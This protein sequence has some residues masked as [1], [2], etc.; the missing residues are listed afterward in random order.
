MHESENDGVPTVAV[1][2]AGASGTLTAVHLARLWRGSRP[3]RVVMYEAA[4]LPGQ[5][6]AYSTDDKCHLLNVPAGRMSAIDDDPGHFLRWIQRRVPGVD[7]ESF[8]PRRAYGWYLGQL[9]A[10][11]AGSI[12]LRVHRRTVTS[13]A[14]VPDG[15]LVQHA[16]GY[17]HAHAV[18]LASG[19]APPAPLIVGEERLPDHPHHIA[20][21]WAPGAMDA[22]RAL[23]GDTGVVL[24][25]GSGLTAVDVALAVSGAGQ[26]R[27][28]V[29]VSRAG[30]LPR[31]H[32]T[33]LP[34]PWP[35][36]LPPGDG[37][38][39]LD[40]LE[41]HIG[42]ELRRAQESGHDWRSVI[43]GLRAHVS[44]L[45]ERLPEAERRRF[46]GGPV[47]N[48][49]VHRHRMAPAVAAVIGELLRRGSLTVFAGGLG[50]LDP[51]EGGWRATMRIDGAQ[52][53]LRA[54][55]VVNCTGPDPDPAAHRGGLLKD[56]IDQGLAR[57]DPLGLGVVTDAFGAVLDA[58][59][60]ADPDLLTLGALRRGQLW[61]STAIPEIRKQAAALA[62]TLTERLTHIGGQVLEARQP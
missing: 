16:D 13:L 25:V 47:R 42:D 24:L 5:G 55:V 32:V 19:N 53:S 56:L 54:A 35:I 2:G 20:D 51:I 10:E 43:D 9:L 12:S 26:G 14:R 30:L 28:V 49:E 15:W 39:T 40:L 62:E 46:L 7:A 41:A 23:A 57:A 31:G 52:A 45:W 18:V 50:R 1:V 6:I 4:G 8:V 58:S 48:W 59:G 29:C 21:P 17:D 34:K 37:D 60:R 27:R 44:A 11:H 61:E 38:L 33:P 22:I 36:E 3:L